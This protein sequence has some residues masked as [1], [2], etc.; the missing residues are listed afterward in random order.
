MDLDLPSLETFVR[1]AE[2]GSFSET[3]K[4]QNISQPAVSLRVAKLESAVGLRLFIRRP[5]GVELTPDGR[6]LIT[7]ARGVL[8]EHERLQAHMAHFLREERGRVRACVDSSIAGHRI[9][10][11]T[12]EVELE[13]G[14]LEL[15]RPGPQ[16]SWQKALID[17][18]VDFAV[19]GTF[20]HAGNVPGLRRFDLDTQRGSTIA[21]NR[22]YFDFDIENFSFPETL[23]STILVPS[24]N[25]ITGYRTFLENW[26]RESYGV[27]PP[28]LLVYDDEEKAREACCAGL[29]VMIFPGDAELR[30]HLSSAGLGVVKTFEFLLPDAFS[31]SIFLRTE[32]KNQLVLKTALRL[33]EK[34]PALQGRQPR[35]APPAGVGHRVS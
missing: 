25:L 33:S 4:L 11:R 30:M 1:L 28:D 22:S 8:H 26:C 16:L 27:L 31:Y 32:E 13:P 6:H 10:A 3:A 12:A 2:C 9:A 34:Y 17:Q 20:L 23:R 18:Q 24:E 35:E 14:S 21:W 19:A 29:G 5:D 15:V 7:V